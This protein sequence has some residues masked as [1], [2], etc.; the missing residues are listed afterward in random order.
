MRADLGARDAA[1]IRR[2]IGVQRGLEVTA[3]LLLILS[4]HRP[5]LV[6]GP[7]LLTVAKIL[8]NMEIGHNVMHGQWDW[9]RDPRIHSTTWEW[10][11][12]STA[13][14]WKH[15]HNYEHHTFTNVVGKDRDLGYSAMRVHP[16]QPWHPVYLLQPL[17][18]DRD[19]GPL[20]EWAIALYDMDRRVRSGGKTSERARR[21]GRAFAR[22]AARSSPRTTSC[23]RRCPVARRAERCSLT[24][25]RTSCAASGRTR[26]SS[27]GTF[28]TASRRSPTSSSSARPAAAGT[29]VS[30]SARA[31]SRA[32][33]CSTS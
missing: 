29:C 28:P 8:D 17:S 33:G 24:S 15:S 31:T 2:I 14:S 3:R 23:S 9:M 6:G 30:C 20:F 26:S 27:W 1:Y 16:D 10:D 5:A 18:R 11:D 21:R 7:P 13:E 19:R 12:A 32:A 25:P 4:R 22:K